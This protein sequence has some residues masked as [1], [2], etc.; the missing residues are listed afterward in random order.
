MPYFG[1]LLATPFGKIIIMSSREMKE[2]DPKNIMDGASR[3]SSRDNPS[4][5][6]SSTMI[7]TGPVGRSSMPPG[8]SPIRETASEPSDTVA[9]SPIS[10]V[11]PED[12][13]ME[14]P[15]REAGRWSQ[16]RESTLNAGLSRAVLSSTESDSDV[17]INELIIQV[18][19]D[20][21]RFVNHH[22]KAPDL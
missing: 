15:L 19:Q 17:N 9:P 12:S 22:D 18:R 13:Y 14:T 8:I 10:P 3:R 2:L 21:D 6:S 16:F 1:L 5:R 4:V 20:V 11:L 7:S